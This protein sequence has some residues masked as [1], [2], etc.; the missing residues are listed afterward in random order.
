MV[1]VTPE[2]ELSHDLSNTHPPPVTL[3]GKWLAREDVHLSLV[4]TAA[5]QTHRQVRLV[6]YCVFLR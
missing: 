1:Q 3:D 2:L 4:H 6:F 5:A